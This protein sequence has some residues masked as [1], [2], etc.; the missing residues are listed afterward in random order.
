[1]DI[2]GRREQKEVYAAHGI[3]E[4]GDRIGGARDIEESPLAN[5]MDKQPPKGKTISD[6]QRE[7]DFEKD[8]SQ[9]FEIGV[10][11]RGSERPADKRKMSELPDLLPK[12]GKKTEDIIKKSVD[13]GIAAA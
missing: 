1:M 13:K 3:Q 4:A 2:R 11:E 7:K 8:A 5:C 9:D 6:W 12:T 10:A